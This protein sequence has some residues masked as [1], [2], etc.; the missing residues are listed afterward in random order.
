L[1]VLAG[2]RSH[3]STVLWGLAELSV[4]PGVVDVGAVL[5]VVTGRE[6]EVVDAGGEVVSGFEV[7]VGVGEVVA[8]TDVVGWDRES[9][10]AEPPELLELPAGNGRTW[11]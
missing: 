4:A 8:A 2:L 3:G 10:G 5:R 9:T 11:R 6:V 7:S 1:R